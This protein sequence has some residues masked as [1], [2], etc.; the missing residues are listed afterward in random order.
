MAPWEDYLKRIYYDPKHPGAFAGPQKLYKVVKSEGKF[1][2]GMHRI[3]KFLHN[4]ESYNQIVR[5]YSFFMFITCIIHSEAINH[6]NYP[7]CNEA[8][9]GLKSSSALNSWPEINKIICSICQ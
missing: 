4:Q 3:R 5:H 7:E 1:N 2:I 8:L 6:S 9:K